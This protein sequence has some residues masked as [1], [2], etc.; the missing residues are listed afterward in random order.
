MTH[1]DVS[2]RDNGLMR[3]QLG[4]VGGKESGMGTT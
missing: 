2:V 1:V 4:W 3:Q